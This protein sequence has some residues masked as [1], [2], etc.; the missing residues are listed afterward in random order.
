[1]KDKR[2]DWLQ[3]QFNCH[4]PIE[5]SEHILKLLKSEAMATELFMSIAGLALI[6]EGHGDTHGHLA[7]TD[8]LVVLANVRTNVDT[9]WIEK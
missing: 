8:A 6:A 7:C 3:S 9:I 5:C 4:D 1:M 2:K